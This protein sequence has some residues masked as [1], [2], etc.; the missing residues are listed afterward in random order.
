M[1]Y[2]S[3]IVGVLIVAA[4]VAAFGCQDSSRVGPS[5]GDA[6]GPVDGQSGE[7]GPEQPDSGDQD[8]DDEQKRWEDGD[9]DGYPR[10]VDNCPEVANPEQTDSDGDGRGDACDNCPDEKN[11]PQANEDGDET[12]DACESEPAGPICRTRESDFEIVKPNIY[13]V[14]DRS[15]SMSNQDDTGSTRM[16]RAK[17]GL[18][19]VAN[20]IAGDVRLGMSTYPCGE[21]NDACN[22]LNYEILSVGDHSA[23]TFQNSY[24]S[25]AFTDSTCPGGDDAGLDG[26]DIEEGGLHLTE[27]GAALR[28]V[29][30]RRLYEGSSPQADRPSRVVLITD[31]YACGCGD[32]DCRGSQP[33]TISA[34]NDLRNRDVKTFVVGFNFDSQQLNEAAEAGGTDAMRS[35]KKYYDA[36]S[37]S[38]LADALEN[39]RD[40]TI[41]CEYELD[42]PPPDS[43]KLWVEVDGTYIDQSNTNGYTYDASSQQLTIH[44][45][46][47][48]TLKN[49][50]GTSVPL[51]IKMGC[52]CETPPCE[53]SANGETCTSDEGC[54]SGVC[55]DGTCEDACHPL[56]A[57]CREA[58]NCCSSSC[59]STGETRVCT[60]Q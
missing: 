36:S 3:R 58:S 52:A 18:D 6:G 35:G 53:C 1:R 2:R 21:S 39:I 48:D 23:S 5:N 43:A 19:T 38:D 57:A 22:T 14:I 45:S 8:G 20:E 56:G 17:S 40:R 34:L 27:T 37:P 24:R 16:E 49:A 59:T 11:F 50:Q 51:E 7:T 54:C 55:N 12:G 31:G 13:I 33:E 46:A 15:S 28:D 42:P 60:G 9:G 41:S 47:C 44:G 32:G 29:L 30:D 4:M 26:L 25:P 10:G